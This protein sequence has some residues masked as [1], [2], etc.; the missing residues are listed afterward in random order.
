M[1]Q[2]SVST[3]AVVDFTSGTNLDNSPC[4]RDFRLYV[5]LFF[6]LSSLK[7]KSAK[8]CKSFKYPWDRWLGNHQGYFV[9]GFTVTFQGTHER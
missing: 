9:S 1:F 4:M 7:K 3:A 2:V 8:I 6:P 5:W